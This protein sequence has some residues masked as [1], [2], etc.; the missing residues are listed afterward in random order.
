LDRHRYGVTVLQQFGDADKHIAAGEMTGASVIEL[1]EAR[2]QVS[3][4]RHLVSF[5]E[6]ERYKASSGLAHRTALVTFF[7]YCEV[8]EGRKP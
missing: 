8:D 3:D 1:A 7:D 5:Q 2:T 6:L 4:E